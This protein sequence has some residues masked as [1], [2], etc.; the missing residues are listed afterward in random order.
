MDKA[1]R[2][3]PL[4]KAEEDAN[5]ILKVLEWTEALR[6]ARNVYKELIDLLA[7]AFGSCY[8][9]VSWSHYEDCIIYND[10]VQ[11]KFAE[12][13]KL[14][15]EPEFPP[16]EIV[17]KVGLPNFNKNL[18]SPDPEAQKVRAKVEYLEDAVK[19]LKDGIASM[20]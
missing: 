18:T 5:E 10:E 16:G 17:S 4:R 20:H 11:S 9:K 3:K 7:A 2:W 1:E 13:E 14:W 12:V 6:N 19:E 8:T 15:G